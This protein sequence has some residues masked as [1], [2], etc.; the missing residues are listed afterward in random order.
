MNDK[1]LYSL[2]SKYSAIY[3]LIQENVSMTKKK[4]IKTD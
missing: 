4:R 3:N 2:W 1:C